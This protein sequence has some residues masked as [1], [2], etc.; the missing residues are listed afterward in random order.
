MSRFGMRGAA[1]IAAGLAG[2]L[3]IS[4]CSGQS[5]EGGGD[6]AADG[7]VTLKVNFWGDMGL[8]A[9]KAAYEKEHPNVK[10]VLNSGEYNAQHEDL[11]KKLVAGSGA[12]DIS[13]VDE[14]FM[15]QFRGQADKFVN[16]LDKG[17]ATYESKYLPWKWQQSKSADGKQ[18]GLGTDVGGLAMC[19]RSDLFK[20]AGLPT[21]RDAVSKLWPTWDDFINVGKQYVDKT[22]KKF[23][24]SATN[25]FNPV[26]AQQPQGFYNEQDQLQME[27]GPKVAFEISM[28]AVKAGLSANLVSFQPNWDQGFKKDQFAVLACPA[29]MIG[30]IQDTAPDQKGKWDI[31]AIPG[32]G[33]NWGGSW[34]TI[35][36]QGKNQDE[37]YKFVE[38]M[39]QP[40][41]QIEVF[42][43]VGN[44][45]S[46]PALYKDPAVLDYKKEFMSNAPTGQIFASTAENLKPQY[47][48]KRNG[49]TRV[50]VENVITRVQQGSLAPDSA[51][52]EAVKEATKAANS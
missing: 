2:T 51:W 9:L 43:T 37:A 41:Q 27:A 45:P 48:G 7:Q 33:G 20:K 15:V 47:L 38:W 16:L 10:I 18:I 36:K 14:G 23:V 21:E 26:L 29:W 39:I 50:A 3:A 49:P 13:A 1:L 46:Q 5:L 35:P 4:A 40:Q 28:K 12:P 8:D 31:A 25:M 32:G 22:G 11:Q 42:K 19:Y 30:H 6:K 44:L 24:D 34:W 17:A 52:P